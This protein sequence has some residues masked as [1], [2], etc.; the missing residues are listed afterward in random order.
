MDR[1]ERRPYG[2]WTRL[3]CRVPTCGQPHGSHLAW[4]APDRSANRATDQV[5]FQPKSGY[6][7]GPQHRTP[8]LALTARRR[9]DRVRRRE[10]IAV[11]AGAAATRPLKARAQ[12]PESPVIGFLSS[13]SEEPYIVAAFRRGLAEQGFLEGRHV[14]IEYRYAHG[15][16]DRLPALATELVSMPVAVIVALPSSPAALAAK[17]A[18]RKIPIAFSVGG[19]VVE[20][21]LVASYN[22]PG[23]P[24]GEGSRPTIP[25]TLLARADE[26]IE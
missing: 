5:P 25:P 9:G 4:C 6:R 3:R 7:P 10:V 14:K 22:S 8:N 13:I 24:H 26:V 21:G 18:T 12:Q 19:D 16:Y 20:L 2:L 11:L 23:P 15:D 17:S 1:R